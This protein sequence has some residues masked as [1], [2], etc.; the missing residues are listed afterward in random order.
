[1]AATTMAA[2]MEATITA[3]AS[4]KGKGYEEEIRKAL[5]RDYQD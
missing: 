3:G 1:M 4:W 2:T 5:L